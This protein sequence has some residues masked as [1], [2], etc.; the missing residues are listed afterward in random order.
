MFPIRLQQNEKFTGL[1]QFNDFQTN[2]RLN[3]IIECNS[4]ALL[5]YAA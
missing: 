4:D 3:V 1:F 2:N 5:M